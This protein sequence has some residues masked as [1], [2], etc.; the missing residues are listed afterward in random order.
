MRIINLIE[1]T[2][3]GNGCFYE[4]GFSFYIETNH[5]KLLLDTGASEVTLENAR[6]VMGIMTILVELWHLQS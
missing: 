2:D 1:D 5:H 4:H 6:K 3:S